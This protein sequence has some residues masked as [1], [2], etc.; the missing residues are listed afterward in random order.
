[1]NV[2]A[3]SAGLQEVVDL[4]VGENAEE[5]FGGKVADAAVII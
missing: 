5:D 2:V 1:M 4:K 3:C